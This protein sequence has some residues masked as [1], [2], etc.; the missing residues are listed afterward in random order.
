MTP[1]FKLV[2]DDLALPK[3]RRNFDSRV[4]S[5]I[6]STHCFDITPI[7]RNN[8]MPNSSILGQVRKAVVDNGFRFPDEP[9]LPFQRCWFESRSSI[10]PG[11]WTGLFMDEK[12]EEAFQLGAAIGDLE[13]RG[14]RKIQWSLYALPKFIDDP[15][16]YT[17]IGLINSR[18]SISRNIGLT[19]TESR[20]IKKVLPPQHWPYLGY[21]EVTIRPGETILEPVFRGASGWTQCWHEV[22]G[23]WHWYR[24]R[25]GIQLEG[26]PGFWIHKWVSSYEKGDSSKGQKQTRYKVEL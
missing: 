11:L 2:A 1:F 26:K 13:Y 22:M 18:H 23:H 24:S 15:L 9:R 14:L 7:D 20:K 8:G 12:Q 16:A 19:Y 5:F 6:A 17:I 3:S 21:T 10:A 25:H 4:W